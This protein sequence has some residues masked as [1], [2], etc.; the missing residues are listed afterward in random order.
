MKHIEKLAIALLHHHGLSAWSF[1]WD[2]AKTRF[3]SCDHNRKVITLSRILSPKQELDEVRNTILH[4][5]AHALVGHKNGHNKI[6]KSKALEIGCDGQ[7]CSDNATVTASFKGSCPNCKTII[8]RHRRKR[9]SCSKCD[10]RFNPKYI[11][12]WE[13]A[14]VNEEP[15]K[16]AK[17]RQLQLTF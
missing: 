2:H 16:V 17:P 10:S 11:F 5:I 13:R 8:H 9:V 15:D 14:S 3:G 6:W 1:S 12:Q 7:R 4:E